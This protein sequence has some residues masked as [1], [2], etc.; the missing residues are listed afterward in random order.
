MESLEENFDRFDKLNTVPLGIGIDSVPSN[1]A[2][3]KSLNIVKTRLLGDFWP[4]GEVAILYGVFRDKDGFSERA[5]IV[6]DENQVVVFAKMYPLR[7][8][9]EIKEIIQFLKT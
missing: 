4:H 2:W 9:P 8:L 6:I 1:K 7:E 3:A 5:N